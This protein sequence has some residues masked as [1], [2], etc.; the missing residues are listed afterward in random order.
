MVGRIAVAARPLQRSY[1][2]LGFVFAVV[3][4]SISYVISYNRE[5]SFG[6]KLVD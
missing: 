4:R 1:L 2:S 5:S 3:A 6:V